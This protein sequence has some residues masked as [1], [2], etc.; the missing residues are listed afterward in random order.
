MGARINLYNEQL[1][2]EGFMQ[3]TLIKTL[4]LLLLNK[5]LIPANNKH[6]I[7]N[8][9]LLNKTHRITEQI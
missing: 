4:P 2:F 9:M 6:E 1:K 3:C 5:L 8:E 7:I